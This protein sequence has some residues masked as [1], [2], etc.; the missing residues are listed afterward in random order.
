[1]QNMQR[2]KIQGS[3]LYTVSEGDHMMH[4]THSEEIETQIESFILKEPKD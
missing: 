1:M 3:I 2:K 4:A